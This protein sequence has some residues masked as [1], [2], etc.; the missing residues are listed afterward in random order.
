MSN[1]ILVLAF[2]AASTLV[3]RFSILRLLESDPEDRL[4]GFPTPYVSYIPPE[5]DQLSFVAY[6]FILHF[7]MM[8]SFT[9][10]GFTAY[11]ALLQS[12]KK[13]LSDYENIYIL[14]DDI[15]HSPSSSQEKEFTSNEKQIQRV[16]NVNDE[17]DLRKKMRLIVNYHHY[18][19]RSFEKCVRCSEYPLTVF[20]FLMIMDSCINIYFMMQARNPNVAMSLGSSFL[21]NNSILLLC[22]YSGQQISNQNEIFRGHVAELPWINKPK[23]FKQSM[24][25]MMNRANVDTEIKPYGVFILNLTSYKDLMKAAFS[26]GNILYT[27]KMTR[28]EH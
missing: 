27:Q 26:L 18:I 12:V 4:R 15:K 23:W 7:L 28:K 20:S 11:T 1:I 13:L 16:D 22:Y 9:F 10:E 24:I 14:L 19:N 3:V 8:I 5:F 21:L 2:C 6:I 17:E 25:I